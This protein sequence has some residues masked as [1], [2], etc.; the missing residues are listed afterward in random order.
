MNDEALK[1]LQDRSNYLYD[2]FTRA[3]PSRS[4]SILKQLCEVDAQ[5]AKIKKERRKMKEKAS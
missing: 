2:L 3:S 4:G 1:A 5:I